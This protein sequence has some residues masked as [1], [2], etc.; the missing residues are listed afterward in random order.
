[1]FTE[2]EQQEL[3]TLLTLQQYIGSLPNK[4]ELISNFDIDPRIYNS[5]KEKGCFKILSDNRGNPTTIEGLTKVAIDN[6]IPHH[7]LNRF[8][9]PFSEQE[10]TT[11]MK[12]F[13]NTQCLI[14]WI[15]ETALKGVK[16]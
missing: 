15:R 3:Y 14:A 6:A 10:W 2:E 16:Q 1:M 11:M 4:S 9:V 7:A 12:D 8:T 5:L 13:P